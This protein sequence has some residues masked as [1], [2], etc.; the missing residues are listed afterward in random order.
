MSGKICIFSPVDN[1]RFPAYTVSR[2]GEAADFDDMQEMRM[3]Y[4]LLTDLAA[5]MGY[6]LAMSGAETFRVEDTIRRILRAYGVECEVFA[7]PNCVSVSLEAANG[8]P[9]MIMRRIGFHGNDLEKLEKLNA[10]SRRICAEKP[11]V[12]QAMS[13]LRETLAAC[14]A[15]RTGVFY[16]GNVLVGLGFCLV[17]GGTLLD[18]LWA[19]L[20]GLIIGLV[21]RFMDRQEANPFFSTILA[22]CLMALPAY[23]AAGLGWLKCPDAAIIGAL[24]ILVPG[25]LITNSMRD[26]IYGDT[27]SGIFR[28]VQVV[29]SALAIALG[30]AAA[31]HLTAGLYG[32]T[33]S[34]TTAW[35]AWA[36][37]LA[38][39]VGCFGFCI[40]F[41]VHGRGLVLCILGGSAAWMVYLSCRALGCDVYAANLFAALFAALYAEIMARVR[42]CPAMPYL[43]VA[44]LPMLPGAGVYYTMS[45]GLEGDMME[46]VAK[47]LETVGIAGSLAVGILLVSTVFRLVNRRRA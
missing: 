45:L 7:I 14:R 9:L 4:Y 20:I 33:G 21:M 37:A 28:I 42:K 22:S 44:T 12:D 34:A 5:T 23:A 41:N 1:H 24:M 25:L 18:C 11:A 2:G 38:V 32:Q 30:T 43:V 6:H 17:F 46:A 47:G 10:L 13:W 15:Y 27:N 29:L 35:P 31:W 19:G 8:K 39:F 40:L 26:I 16:L 36:Q 3:D